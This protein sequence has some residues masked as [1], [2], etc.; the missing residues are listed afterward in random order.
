[1]LGGGRGNVYGALLGAIAIS[2]LKNG[3]NMMG[4]RILT[5][6]MVIG[7]I[8]IVILAADVAKKEAK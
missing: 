8:L 6:M 4:W 1:M 7:F 5:Q 2:I 3:M